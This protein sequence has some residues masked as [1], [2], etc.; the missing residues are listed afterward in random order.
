MQIQNLIQGSPE[1]IAYRANHFN[2]SDAPAMLGLSPYKTRN[3]LLK[4]MATG[5]FP[6]IGPSTQ[7][8][9]DDGHRFEALY[10]PMAEEI[11]GDDLYPVTG[12]EGKLSASFDGL[13]MSQKIC[14]E[15][16][17][18][19]NEI[20]KATCAADL[21]IHLRV[22]MEQQIM[23]AGA[24]KCL[25]SASKWDEQGNLIE[26]VHHW[27]TSD[28]ELRTKLI[29]GWT[30]FAVDLENYVHVQVEEKPEAEAIMALPALSVQIRGEVV[31]SN[32]PEFK[33]KAELF[34]A[35]I[36]TDPTTD[37][38]FANA[39]E[40]I[41]FCEKAEN[42]LELAKSAAIA[43][44]SSI[45]EL[46]RTVDNIKE[47]LRRK[48]LD[49][50][51]IVK[52][53]KEQIK[54]EILMN[55]RERFHEHMTSL[56]QETAPIRLN[57]TQPDFAAA[58]KNKR[59]LASLHEAVDTT[60]AN[61]KISADG[62]AA[63]VRKKLA[64]F[65]LNTV[66]LGFLFNDLQQIIFKQEDDFKAL[67]DLRITRH[68]EAE[69]K[70]IEDL[71]K[72]EV[73]RQQAER[74]EKAAGSERKAQAEADERNRLA[75]IEQKRIDGEREAL[76]AEKRKFQEQQQAEERAAEVKRQ[77]ELKTTAEAEEKENQTKDAS[78]PTPTAEDLVMAI[79]MD[80]NVSYVQA[81][82]WATTADFH[83]LI[84]EAT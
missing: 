6:E 63:D 32:L 62:I 14:W 64:W 71:A 37:E 38:D 30:Q 61:A 41:K 8:R 70:R 55:G 57:L 19:N 23:L 22:Q 79:A 4:E 51:A 34:I 43:Q 77:A 15:H 21:G 42:S 12:S 48:R 10:R 39:E 13:T 45:D 65:K 49:L 80:F 1:W 9:F 76:E 69:Q 82:V 84:Q 7:K 59:T 18:L 78:M 66:D 58:M 40:T 20:R 67:I 74:A 60:L 17:S 46:M 73:H 75:A 16:K 11:V 35:S 72:A 47:Q 2:A 28:A 27:Y 25:F 44:T 53:K 56:E 36:K 24:E 3:D 52:N 5:I 26:E 83:S 29:Q 33:N 50:T 68:K 31:L 54:T 81:L